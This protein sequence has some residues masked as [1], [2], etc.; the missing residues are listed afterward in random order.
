MLI[1]MGQPSAPGGDRVS[2][3][4]EP[5]AAGEARR[6]ATLLHGC[7]ASSPRAK[8]KAARKKAAPRALARRHPG[9]LAPLVPGARRPEVRWERETWSGS[10]SNRRRDPEMD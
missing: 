3:G 5:C 2:E 7:A 4:R 9:C 8:G 1:G 10:T 6:K